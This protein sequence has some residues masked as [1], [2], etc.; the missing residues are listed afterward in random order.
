[1]IT[2]GLGAL[3]LEVAAFLAEK[4]AK[5]IVLV[6][7]RNLPPRCLW[8][9][10]ESLEIQRILSLEAMGVSVFTVSADITAATAASQLRSALGGLSLPPALGVVHAAGM[11]ANQ[12]VM[13]TTTGAF[14]S[15]IAPKIFGAMALHETFPSKTLDFMVLFSSCG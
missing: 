2:G 10:Q 6:S 1:M 14:N 4:G 9:S 3:G 15:V 12:T 13:E 7:R 11:L 8:D 5:R